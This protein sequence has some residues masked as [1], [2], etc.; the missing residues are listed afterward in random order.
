MAHG[1]TSVKYGY[2]DARF[3][4]EIDENFYCCICYNVLK[5]ART[6]P[7]NE[8]VFCL[9]CITQHLKVNS[10]KSCPVCKERLSQDALRRP[11]VL[12]NYLSKQKINCEYASRGCRKFIRVENLE[13]HLANCGY[14]PVLCS[15]RKCRMEINR[16]DK[17]LHEAEICEHRKGKPYDRGQMQ[18]EVKTLK[19]SV[20]DLDRK[21]EAANNVAQNN[22]DEMKRIVKTMDGRLTHLD[23][24]MD[25]TNR[26]SNEIEQVVKEEVINVR[27]EVKDVK[28]NVFKVNA[29]M[30]EVK[31]MMKQMFEKLSMLEPVNKMP[32][33]VANPFDEEKED[34]LIAG[35][36]KS[37]KQ[38]LRSTEIFSWAKNGWFNVSQMNEEHSGA[39][40]YI[41]RRRTLFVVGGEN[42]KTIERLDLHASHPEW[43]R[44]LVR[45]P[46]AFDDH[47]TVIYRQRVI[48][49]G[50]YFYEKG[51]SNV[52]SEQER[53][54]SVTR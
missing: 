54:L 45:L 40:S 16:Q 47:K 31:N 48:H 28:E 15:N 3:E 21:V 44:D 14:A 17:V 42:T 32:S 6:C 18:E 41:L 7:N 51:L 11:R 35:G 43:I 26:K 46:C 1:S 27:K 30:G 12:N 5:E 23:T 20:N 38:Y 24:K 34:I 13:T 33:L 4:K 22:H 9:A 19:E 50:G 39:S 2:D 29:E 37:P 25:A 8:H 36:A 49:I 52:I 10:Q 53:T